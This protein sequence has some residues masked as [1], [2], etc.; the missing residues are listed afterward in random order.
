MLILLSDDL[1]S[2]PEETMVRV[3]EFLGVNSTFRSP[4]WYEKRHEGLSP[5]FWVLNKVIASM[6][7][8]VIDALN[9]SMAKIVK[10]KYAK[11]VIERLAYK[12]GYPPMEDDIRNML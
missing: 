5:R 8:P 7:S 12:R 3:F 9:M 1:K 4:S 11:K 6:P 2:N 10:Y